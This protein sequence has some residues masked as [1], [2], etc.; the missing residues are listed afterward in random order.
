MTGKL[1]SDDKNKYVFGGFS[2]QKGKVIGNSKTF[3]SKCGFGGHDEF[4]DENKEMS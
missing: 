2:I 3:N 1:P 4:N